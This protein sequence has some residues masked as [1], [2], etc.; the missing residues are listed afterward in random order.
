MKKIVWMSSFI[1]SLLFFTLIS[2]LVT[3]IIVL[4]SDSNV[5]SFTQSNGAHMWIGLEVSG[6]WQGVAQTLNEHGFDSVLWLGLVQLLPFMLINIILIRLFLLYRRGSFFAIE[7][8][9]CFKWLG[10]V[11]LAQFALVV[12]YPSLL[13]TLLNLATGSDIGR[14]VA[15][16]DTD[17]IGLVM[18]LIIYVIGWIMGQAQQLQ[19]EQE[20][21][22]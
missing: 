14:V 22:I 2:L 11:L 8:I 18:G 19:K 12:C 6:S 7:N 1:L 10:G 3:S 5:L 9:Q 17:I 4:F 15:I 21:V 16:Q 13:I 20:L